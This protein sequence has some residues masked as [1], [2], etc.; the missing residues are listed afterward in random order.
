MK[1]ALVAALLTSVFTACE[2][3]P[4]Q[5]FVAAP[6][7]AQNQW[8]DGKTAPTIDTG[9]SQGFVQPTN[10]GTN[11]MEICNAQEKMMAWSHA[12][13][14]P[15]IPPRKAGGVDLAGGDTWQ[16]FTME[17]AEKVLCQSL[18]IEA[19]LNY[20]GD[21]N[22]IVAWYFTSTRK[23]Y[24]LSLFQ[25][26]TGAMTFKSRV[27]GTFGDHTYSLVPGQQIYK[28]GQKMQIEWGSGA[29]VCTTAN[30]D[31]AAELTDAFIATFQPG[32]PP[33]PD[34]RQNSHCILNNIGDLAYLFIPSAGVAVWANQ[35]NAPQPTPS[36]FIR[37]DANLEKV[38]PFS[39]A[40]STLKLD[41]EGPIGVAKQLGPSNKTC[42][43]KMGMTYADLLGD[44][45][46]VTGQS[47]LDTDNTNELLGGLT[48][49][50]ERFHFDVSG[51]DVNM[52]DKTLPDDNVIRDNDRPTMDDVATEWDVDQE[53]L[54][55]L[56]NDRANNSAT[57]AKDLHMMG[58]IYADFVRQVQ[59]AVNA[60]N[61]LNGVATH[62]IGDPACL[63]VDGD[64]SKV[65]AGCSGFEGFVIP[66]DPARIDD[67][68]TLDP[69]NYAHPLQLKS[70]AYGVPAVGSALAPLV[71]GMKP[72]NQKIAF[73]DGPN[74]TF[75]NT[76]GGTFAFSFQRLLTI[77]AKGNVKN[78]PTDMKDQRFMWKAWSLA[79]FKFL[80]AEKADG[81]TKYS[82]VYRAPIQYD[83]VF[84]DSLGGQFEISEYIDRRFVSPTQD[85]TDIVITADVIDDIVNDYEF[86]RDLYRG[87]TG[88][89]LAT[90]NNVMDPPGKDPALV[91]NVFGAPAIFSGWQDEMVN[92]T[93]HT[94]YQCATDATWQPD[95]N[96]CQIPPPFD[97]NT[98]DFLRDEHGRM[99]LSQYKGAFSTTGTVFHLGPGSDASGQPTA[100]PVKI[101]SDN[102]QPAIQS[103]SIQIPLHVNSYDLTSAFVDPQH[104]FTTILV[105]W[106]PKQPG[107]GFPIALS[108]TRD[109][110]ITTAQAD[111]TG[112]TISANIDYDDFVPGS[113]SKGQVLKAVETTDFL[114]YVFLCLDPNTND[115]LA[116]KMY[117]PAANVLDW[118]NK[119]PNT[120]D[121]CGLIVRFSPY[122]NFPDYITSLTNGVRLGITQG[123]GFGRVV[124]VT[125]FAP[126]Q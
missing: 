46:Q 102:A 17:E 108:G 97:V 48:H 31:W 10:T 95:A 11:A 41:A 117:T 54:G 84:F 72:G 34:C 98:Q 126:G 101:K 113:T 57:G 81:T 79:F 22:E 94:A 83:D 42:T 86:S 38:L 70:Q 44:C 110:F 19:G 100:S 55:K 106:L 115:M 39:L 2:D 73:C 87:E 66:T 124:D 76:I 64:L 51:I 32:L 111:L 122:N 6:P 107:V 59:D 62:A 63:P 25:G 123:G 93:L 53:T 30:C 24:E 91:S 43:L 29:K 50:S 78:L 13:T 14:Q 23:I 47:Q 28:D 75:C 26:Y 74:F 21:N 12:F 71:A 16:G 9:V 105:P 15:I 99:I 119:H 88:I 77:W 3:G 104:P 18:N 40:D 35:Y 80:M 36:I 45:V 61:T 49:G 37:I 65:A 121:D 52:T 4:K 112:T 82:D 85:P 109:K 60:T 116:V 96:H 58:L 89:Y 114:G 5:N 67:D 8:N 27:G 125:L 103:I 69:G 90:R 120:V 1:R 118:I 7:G 56:L 33:E 92:G 20:W 68:A